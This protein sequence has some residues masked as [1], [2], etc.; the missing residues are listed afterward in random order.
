MVDA[1]GDGKDDDDEHGR[2]NE[3]Y[4]GW[5]VRMGPRCRVELAGSGKEIVVPDVDD[6]DL[7]MDSCVVRL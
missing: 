1:I 5:S 6:V 2:R 4:N 7:G 3:T